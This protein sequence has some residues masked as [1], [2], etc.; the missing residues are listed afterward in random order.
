MWSQ[1]PPDSSR[2][3]HPVGRAAHGGRSTVPG[4]QGP[5]DPD[6][7]RAGGMALTLEEDEPEAGLGRAGAPGLGNGE[8]EPIPR[9]DR[10]LLRAD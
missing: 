4:G 7:A 8:G 2:R 6:G 9:S 3:E 10:I 1:A 5:G